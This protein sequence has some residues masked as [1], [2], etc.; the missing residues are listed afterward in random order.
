MKKLALLSVAFVSLAVAGCHKD[1]PEQLDQNVDTSVNSSDLNA[2][3]DQAA[4]V[5]SEAQQLENQAAA[6]NSE[7]TATENASGPATPDDENVQGM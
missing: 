3:S 7:A 2:L 6:L 4:N 5:A 1:N